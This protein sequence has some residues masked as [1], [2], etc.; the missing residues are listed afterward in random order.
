[1]DTIT[2]FVNGCLFVDKASHVTSTIESKQ[3]KYVIHLSQEASKSKYFKALSGYLP[4]GGARKVK[5]C[6]CV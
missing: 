2:L 1:M 3:N 5:T 6:V 4:W